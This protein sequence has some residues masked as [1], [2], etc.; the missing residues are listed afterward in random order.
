MQTDKRGKV[1][2]GI[3]HIMLANGAATAGKVMH[4]KPLDVRKGTGGEFSHETRDDVDSGTLYIAESRG[5]DGLSHG[6]AHITIAERKGTH[7]FHIK[8]QG[9]SSALPCIVVR[10]TFS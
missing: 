8:R 4:I 9:M 3:G 2:K 1:K 7:F 10:P 5:T 6:P